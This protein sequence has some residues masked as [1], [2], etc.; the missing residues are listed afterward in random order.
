MASKKITPSQVNQALRDSGTSPPTYRVDGKEVE[1]P[2]NTVI[3]AAGKTRELFDSSIID[4][5]VT[6][7]VISNRVKTNNTFGESE[8]VDRFRFQ[9]AKYWSLADDGKIR[10]ISKSMPSV[11]FNITFNPMGAEKEYLTVASTSGPPSDILAPAFDEVILVEPNSSS[12]LYSDVI[13]PIAKFQELFDAC[14]AENVTFEDHCFTVSSPYSLREIEQFTASTHTMYASVKPTYNFYIQDYE[15]AISDEQLGEPVLPS[16]Y[17]MMTEMTKEKDEKPNDWYHKHITLYDNLKLESEKEMLKPAKSRTSFDPNGKAVQYFDMYGRQLSKALSS[18]KQ[19]QLTDKF[20]NMYFSHANIDMIKKFN[21]RK[22]LFPMF[23][24]IEFSTDQ[25]TEFTQAIADTGMGSAIIN[26]VADNF[27]TSATKKF[28]EQTKTA[29]QAMSDTVNANEVISNSSEI[30]E[31]NRKIFDVSSWYNGFQAGEKVAPVGFFDKKNSIFVGKNNPEVEVTDNPKYNLYRSLMAVVF[32]SK[33]R[34][35]VRERTRTFKEMMSGQKCQTETVFYRV[36]KRKGGEAGTVIQNFWLPNSNDIDVHNFVDT[37][38]KYGNVYTYTIYAYELVFGSKYT[39]LEPWKKEAKA[40]FVIRTQPSLQIV[41]VP[42]FSYT[43]RL[44][45]SPPVMPDVEV[46]PYKGVSDRIKINLS[47]NV[48]R[49][50]LQP[51]IISPEDQTINDIIRQAQDRFP[52]EPIRYESDDHASMFEIFRMNR[53]PNSY[54]DFEGKLLEKVFSDV[55]PE[56]DNKATSASYVDNV[57]PNKKYWYTFRSVDNH[58][59]ISYPSPIYQ[60]EIVDDHGAIYSIIE[61]VD[62]APR[63]PK[64]P[65]K[66]LKRLMQIIPSYAHGI[67]N[68]E[69]SGVQ[70]VTSVKEMWSKDT[71]FLGVKDETLWGKKFKIRLTSKKT[72]RKIDINVVFEHEHLKIQPE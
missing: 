32:S 10:F 47:G 11:P 62:F 25:M 51:M 7:S 16:L 64:E 20:S 15:I 5:I 49:Y 3:T 67:L 35:L 66:E 13:D 24:D 4:P 27:L 19:S 69:K 23:V 40:G 22:E 26:S 18:T 21:N 31:N 28:V 38:V 56:S 8:I 72:G 29:V 17:V 57:M 9:T 65:V 46:V 55:D 39:Y 34:Q 58:G 12:S 42:Y 41:E 36:E 59:H 33:T 14:V 6:A 52:D 37:Q 43:N 71:L 2:L 68:E 44:M 54:K 45:D 1:R 60:V 30:L 61:V 53:H 50:N 70:N 48:G 63:T